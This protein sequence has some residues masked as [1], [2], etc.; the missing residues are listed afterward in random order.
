[1]VLPQ[2]IVIEKGKFAGLTLM[3]IIRSR[4]EKR[5]VSEAKDTLYP[6]HC[7]GDIE[8]NNVSTSHTVAIK[9]N[10]FM[11]VSF[12]YP[13]QLDR[14]VL[15]PS[16]FFFPAGETTFMVG[17]SGSSKTTIGQLLMRFYTPTSGEILIDG[18]PV[19]SLNLNWIRNNVTLLEQR[20][21]LFN[22]SVFQNIA[23]GS[24]SHGDVRSEAVENSIELAMLQNTIDGLP[25][26]IDTCVGPGGSFLSGG[27]RQRVAI[28]RARLRD[29]PIL[30]LD[31]PTSALDHTNRVAVMKAIRK[32][33]LG[34]TT[35][36]ITHDM[37]QTFKFTVN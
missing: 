31:E 16:T 15:S 28:A 29:T 2:M 10:I 37:S 23:F 13:N 25:E 26:G 32:W 24:Q 3:S 9:A 34:K 22:D 27:Q 36:V 8:V 7:E 6:L 19:Q 21:V 4:A 17:K 18:N 20:S 5:V 35:I 12:A 14:V 11:Q 33:R 30:I 1:M